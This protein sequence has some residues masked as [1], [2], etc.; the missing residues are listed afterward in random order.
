MSSNHSFWRPNVPML[1]CLEQQFDIDAS[2]RFM[3]KYWT[4]SI[5]TA[6]TYF[7]LAYVIADRMKNRL[8][9]HLRNTLG[10]WSSLLAVF[11]SLGALNIVPEAVQAYQEGGWF[12]L[13]CDH[14]KVRHDA[15]Q[16]FWI[17]AFMWSKMLEFGDTVFIVAR[18]QKLTF[19][20]TIH[21]ALTFVFTCYAY[22]DASSILRLPAAM[23]Y[24]IHT[25]MYTYFALRAFGIRLPRWLQM[26]ITT[27]Q[28]LQMVVGAFGIGRSMW[29]HLFESQSSQPAQKSCSI[30]LSASV[31]GV[32]LYLL[33]LALFVN[34]FIQTYVRSTKPI[35]T[36]DIESIK[37]KI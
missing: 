2:L 27:A 10:I 29:W 8:P 24:S 14:S 33:Y 17:D 25:L 15:Q 9:Y 19:L 16:Y 28:I 20:H 13:I 32:A 1:N 21:H 22:R 23:N 6:A 37:K 35:R 4:Y 11:S 7:I 5:P 3:S 18:K 12:G 36:V 26:T 31:S 30:S 34:F